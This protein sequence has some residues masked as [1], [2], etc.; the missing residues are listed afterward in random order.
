M[1]KI[2]LVIFLSFFIS[3][4]SY[5][6]IISFN[7]CYNLGDDANYNSKINH[8]KNLEKNTYEVDILNKKIKNITIFRDDYLKDKPGKSKITTY[9][10]DVEYIDNN[11]INGFNYAKL[12]EKRQKVVVLI[13]IKEKT[14][15][16]KA[17]EN[18]S[19]KYQCE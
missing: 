4:I 14:I 7:N 17:G 16:I 18:I 15:D 3:S 8:K 2:I 5:S 12:Q 6:K 13:K 9:T 10:W 11:Y 19:I 1:K